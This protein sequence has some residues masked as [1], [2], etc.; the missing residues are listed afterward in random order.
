MIH[1]SLVSYIDPGTGSM[2][3]TILVGVLGAG[4]YAAREAAVK[5][6]FFFSG[7]HAVRKEEERMPYAIFADNKRY[8]N[9]FGPICEEFE[10]RGEELN[11]LTAS[12]DV[13]ALERDYQ[14]V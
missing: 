14:H 12:H 6:R 7:G 5:L 13:A 3:F 1:P 4:L 9:V 2:L 10:A 8:W 11:Y